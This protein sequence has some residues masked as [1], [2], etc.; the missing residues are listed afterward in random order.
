MGENMHPQCG[1][2]MMA[3]EMGDLWGWRCVGLSDREYDIGVGVCCM[4]GWKRISI[5]KVT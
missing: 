3:S 1:T 4:R 5:S 2:Y